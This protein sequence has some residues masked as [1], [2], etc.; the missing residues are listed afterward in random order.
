TRTSWR[1]AIIQS[2]D[3]SPG[4]TLSVW[5]EYTSYRRRSDRET[6]ILRRATVSP[7]FTVE[8]SDDIDYDLGPQHREAL[9]RVG[10]HT[11]RLDG[12]LLPWQGVSLR[13]WPRANSIEGQR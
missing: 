2:V 8:A 9:R 4:E 10:P 13:W 12:T 3:L 6:L 1:M 5:A 11:Y 7:E